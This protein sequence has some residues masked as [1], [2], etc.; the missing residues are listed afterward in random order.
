MAGSPGAGVMLSLH[1]GREGGREGGR[2]VREESRDPDAVLS[3][4]SNIHRAPRLTDRP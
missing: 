2:E 3:N 4:N 1:R